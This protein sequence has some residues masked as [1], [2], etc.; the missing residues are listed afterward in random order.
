MRHFC[1]QYTSPY[2]EVFTT[3]TKDLILL[4]GPAGTFDAVA[5]VLAPY[6]DRQIQELTRA[7]ARFG[8][9]DMKVEERRTQVRAL[10]AAALPGWPAPG[11]SAAGRR[12]QSGRSGL[13]RC[14]SELRAQAV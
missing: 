13:V 3:Q 14:E 8:D 7:M 2:E 4:S 6:V 12:E 10:L 5:A 9:V 11:R 1:A